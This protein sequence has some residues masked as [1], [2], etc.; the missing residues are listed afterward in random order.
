M[1]NRK[2]KPP[3][4]EVTPSV[5][6]ALSVHSERSQ[7]TWK[8]QVAYKGCPKPAARSVDSSGPRPVQQSAS[9]PS[10]TTAGIERMPRFFARLA[11]VGFFM[12]RTVTSHDGQATRLMSRMVSSHAGQPALK[13]SIFRFAAIISSLNVSFAESS[14]SL[15]WRIR[16]TRRH[17]WVSW[18]THSKKMRSRSRKGPRKQMRLSSKRT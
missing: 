14:T 12:S 13:T 17:F 7:V 4:Y 3:Q 18:A 5:V 15:Y 8:A 9:L 11:T 16:G 6:T 10:I 1:A 2:V